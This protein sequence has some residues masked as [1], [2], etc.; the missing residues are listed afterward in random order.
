M[1]VKAEI[2]KICIEIDGLIQD[3]TIRKD[4][5][6]TLLYCLPSLTPNLRQQVL[7]FYRGIYSSK[8]YSLYK[9]LK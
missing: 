1:S 5:V 7:S 9:L 3:G 8:E 6:E 4:Q 2:E